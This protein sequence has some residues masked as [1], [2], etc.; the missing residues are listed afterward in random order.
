MQK[1]KTS[2][3]PEK[4]F[5]LDAITVHDSWRL[6]K[7]L[8]ELVDGFEALS[9]IYPAVSIFGSA[10][11]RPGDEPYERTVIIARRL[12]E[13]SF[14][15]ITGG[16]P[17]IMEAGNKGA[18]EGGAS[19]IGLNIM[20]PLE[21]EPNPFSNVKLDFQYFF[22]RKVMFVKYAQAYIGM[23]GGLGT[24]DEIFEALTLIQT[25]RIKP[26][27]VI[28]VGR[29]YWSGL[30]DWIKGT[31]LEQH[32]ISDTDM[33]LFSVMDDPDEVVRTIKRYVIV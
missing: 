17:G 7:I 25:R 32:Y 27:P 6:F 28:L 22:V 3:V 23:P 13:M 12:G 26:F 21:Q 10:R 5:L 30:I 4:Q 14:N 19:S 18:R 8:A 9:D 15:V 24:L 2:D 1:R 11:V 33:D 16:G 31:L 20:L 29:D